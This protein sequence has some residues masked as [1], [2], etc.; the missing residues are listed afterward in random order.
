MTLSYER[1]MSDMDEIRLNT[2]EL[3][4]RAK[5]L[6]AGQRVLLS[7][8]AYTSRDAAHKRI[9]EMLDRGEEPPYPL[10]GAAIYYAGPT[11]APAGPPPAPGW[12]P[13]PRGFWTWG[14]GA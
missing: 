13:T 5:D 14:F 2:S 8:T 10:D 7:G 1:E 11:P 3:K 9:T 4:D 6:R 12:T